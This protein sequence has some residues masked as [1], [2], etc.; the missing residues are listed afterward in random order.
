MTTKDEVKKQC[1]V[2]G[3][4]VANIA[5]DKNAESNYSD[6]NI[7]MC[8]I[9]ITMFKEAISDIIEQRGLEKQLKEKIEEL[10][11]RYLTNKGD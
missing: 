9:S 7:L 4:M 3:N 6:N 11:E 1:I 5:Y 2:F 8:Y 10:G